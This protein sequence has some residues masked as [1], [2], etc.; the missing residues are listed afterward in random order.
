MKLIRL[1]V[2]T[3]VCFSLLL[4]SADAQKKYL[5]QFKNEYRD[6]GYCT[7]GI[8]VGALPMGIAKTVLRSVKMEQEDRA[9]ANLVSK[10]RN[11]KIYIVSLTDGSEFERSAINKLK[12]NL[13]GKGHCDLLVEASGNGG[14]VSLYNTGK[15]N[16]IGHLVMLVHDGSDMILLHMNTRLSIEDMKV[17]ANE[18]AK[19]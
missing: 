7:F 3:T 8:G 11:L 4:S 15:D 18:I 19:G 12:S 13:T 10:V 1:L 5:R 9:W 17:V 2:A 16:K 6:M 14:H